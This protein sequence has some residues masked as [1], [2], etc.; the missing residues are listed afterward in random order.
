MIIPLEITDLL[1]KIKSPGFHFNLILRK[2]AGSE[3]VVVGS[4]SMEEVKQIIDRE[5]MTP[6]LPVAEVD[7]RSQGPP[8]LPELETSMDTSSPQSATIE[9]NGSVLSE[10]AQLVP[11]TPAEDVPFLQER[12]LPVPSTPAVEVPLLPE[13]VPSDSDDDFIKPGAAPS[14]P[15]PNKI[16]LHQDLPDLEQPYQDLTDSQKRSFAAKILKVN[17]HFNQISRTIS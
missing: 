4:M 2:G 1:N 3:P 6:A 16:I 10:R 17:R 15:D 7:A 8:N 13:Q 9:E 12:V 11:S 14:R 5:I